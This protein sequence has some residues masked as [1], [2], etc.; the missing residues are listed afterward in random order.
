MPVP[1]DILV[2]IEKYCSY[3]ERCEGETREKL[4]SYGLG[5]VDIDD[6]IDRLISDRFIND[7]R[8]TENYIRGKLNLKKWGK[9]KIRYYLSLKKI[10]SAII[11]KYLHTIPEE[12]YR[13]ILDENIRQWC[14]INPYNQNTKPKLYRYLKGKGFENEMIINQLKQLHDDEQN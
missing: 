5:N 12:E 13:I 2:K 1:E 3:Q 14:K 4:R 10:D 11:S 7:E 9:I 6:I 8:F